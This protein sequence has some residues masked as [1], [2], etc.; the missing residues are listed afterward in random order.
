MS[1]MCLPFFTQSWLPIP[2]LSQNPDTL[3]VCGEVLL[4]M[5]VGTSGFEKT[6]PFLSNGRH[7]SA[8]KTSYYFKDGI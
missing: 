1:C 3:N 7:C 8:L 2:C 6:K 5:S 4:F